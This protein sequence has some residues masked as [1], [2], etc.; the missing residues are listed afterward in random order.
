MP[1]KQDAPPKTLLGR[2]DAENLE[3]RELL[4]AVAAELE[5]MAMLEGK[6]ENREALLGRSGETALRVA[7][8]AGSEESILC[9]SRIC[10]QADIFLRGLYD[11]DDSERGFIVTRLSPEGEEIHVP[12]LKVEVIVTPKD[13]NA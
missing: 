8:P 4:R 6:A 3:L 11:K 2:L 13:S 5:R 9:A 7:M 1:I 10:M 12:L